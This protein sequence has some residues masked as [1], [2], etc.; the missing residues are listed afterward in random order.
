MHILHTWLS[1]EHQ[2]ITWHG[3]IKD[4]SCNFYNVCYWRSS[5]TM[6]DGEDYMMS[7]S[8]LAADF[9]CQELCF[10]WFFNF[11]TL[12]PFILRLICMY[13]TL[14]WR[15]IHYFDFF[16]QNLYFR[17]HSLHHYIYI[18]HLGDC[19]LLY[20]IIHHIKH[21]HICCHLVQTLSWYVQ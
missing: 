1:D 19:F 7:P 5:D 6:D 2:L 12:V 8:A 9:L 17:I 13:T 21:I 14:C 3:L 16:P 15:N 20:I 11:Y 10:L 18:L 4:T